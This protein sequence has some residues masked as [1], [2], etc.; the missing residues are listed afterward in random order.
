MLPPTERL[1]DGKA[2][3]RVGLDM[4][5]TGEYGQEPEVGRTRARG[6]GREESVAS[7]TALPTLAY[8]VNT[9]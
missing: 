3:R 8:A 9:C 1:L 6:G 2:P 4:G 7:V 5:L